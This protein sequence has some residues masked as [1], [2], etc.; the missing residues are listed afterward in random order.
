MYV[1]VCSYYVT[2]KWFQCTRFLKAPAIIRFRVL[3]FNGRP[4]NDNNDMLFDGC[5]GTFQCEKSRDTSDGALSPDTPLDLRRCASTATEQV[6]QLTSESTT[7]VSDK[8]CPNSKRRYV[9]VS[10]GVLALVTASMVE[11]V[12]SCEFFVL[13][14]FSSFTDADVV[15][16]GT[17]TSIVRVWWGERKRETEIVP[18][19]RRRWTSVGTVSVSTL[20]DPD[21]RSTDAAATG[22]SEHRAPPENVTRNTTN[23]S[24]SNPSTTVKRAPA[25]DHRILSLAHSTILASIRPPRNFGVREFRQ[26]VLRSDTCTLYSAPGA[27]ENRTIITEMSDLFTSVTRPLSP[28]CHVTITAV[29]LGLII[30]RIDNLSMLTAENLKWL[31]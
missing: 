24:R 18:S 11:V 25:H 28:S 22:V 29:E 16:S 15:C 31:D 13:G 17:Q 4:I 10:C 1:C 23:S 7:T 14:V 6:Y 3:H 26:C 12:M 30:F 20:I 19:R 8:K 5:I 21:T 27:T 9:W 2:L